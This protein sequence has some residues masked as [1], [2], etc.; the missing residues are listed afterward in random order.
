LFSKKL[1]SFEFLISLSLVNLTCLQFAFIR[2]FF[3]PL[4]F[5]NIEKQLKHGKFGKK[6]SLS[7]AFIRLF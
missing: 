6:I 1:K 2:L 3:C 5:T 4:V 7:L